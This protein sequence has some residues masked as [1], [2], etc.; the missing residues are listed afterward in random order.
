MICMQKYISIYSDGMIDTESDVSNTAI[1]VYQTKDIKYDIYTFVFEKYVK[2]LFL[3]S[4]SY[5]YRYGTPLIEINN[6]SYIILYEDKHYFIE[7]DKLRNID[8]LISEME[9]KDIPVE[10]VKKVLEYYPHSPF[11]VKTK[12]IVVNRDKMLKEIL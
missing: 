8:T 7:S 9:T 5:V 12:I 6:K 10:S 1:E 3:Y 4:N 2:G 11:N